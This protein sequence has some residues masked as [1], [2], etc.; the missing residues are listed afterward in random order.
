MKYTVDTRLPPDTKILNKTVLGDV[1]QIRPQ[2]CSLPMCRPDLG[3]NDHLKVLSPTSPR[4]FEVV[5]HVGPK[6]LITHTLTM[7]STRPTHLWPRVVAPAGQGLHSTSSTG[8]FGPRLPDKQ[9]LP[10]PANLGSWLHVFGQSWVLVLGAGHYGLISSLLSV[11]V[12]SSL[13]PLQT[14]WPSPWIVH[15]GA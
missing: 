9:R 15:I 14:A 5:V 13:E 1:G 3:F 8:I 12:S 11:I 6:V 7:T 10:P 2:L 4:L